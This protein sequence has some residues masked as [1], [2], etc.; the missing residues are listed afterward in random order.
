MCPPR[1]NQSYEYV[2]AAVNNS[3]SVVE[4]SGG[5]LPPTMCLLD[6]G[7]NFPPPVSKTRGAIHVLMRDM[8]RVLTATLDARQGVR[9]SPRKLYK[10][11]FVPGNFNRPA[12]DGAQG[13]IDQTSSGRY[14]PGKR[15]YGGCG[16]V[17]CEQSASYVQRMVPEGLRP[18]V[19]PHSG[20]TANSPPVF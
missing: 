12:G 6:S 10:A 7:L 1:L 11:D 8:N 17:N 19:Q 15:Y 18:T 16:F 13:V 14:I 2:L 4:L 20:F 5:I 9:R 3:W